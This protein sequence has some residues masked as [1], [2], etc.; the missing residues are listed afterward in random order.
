M[1]VTTDDVR[2]PPEPV[3]WRE[4]RTIHVMGIC[5]SAM[6]AFAQMLVKRGYDVQGSDRGAYPPMSTILGDLG[7]RVMEGYRADNLIPRPDVVVVGNVI[8][9]DYEEAVA[10]REAGIPHCS[11]PQA[12]RALFLADVQ[13]V[14]VAGT[15]GKTTTSSMAAWILDCAGLEPGFMIGGVT[16]NFGVS[17]RAGRGGNFVVEGD[18]YDTAY[19]DKGPKFLHY[20]PHVAVVNNIEYDHA[21]IYPSVEAI[22]QAFTRFAAI[23]DPA[24]RI[25]VADNDVRALRATEAAS[26]PRWT[27]GLGESADVGATQI[28]ETPDGLAFRLRFPDGTTVSTSLPMWGAHNVRNAVAAAAAAHA[29]GVEPSVIA[30]ALP[31]F[32]PPKKRQELRGTA[33]G[34]PVY[35]DFGH[36]PTAIQATLSAFRSRYYGRRVVAVVEIQS[37]TARRRVFQQGFAD[38]LAHA[39]VVH[40]GPPL[41]KASDALKEDE[42]L[43]LAA[44]VAALRSGGTPAFT[45]SSVTAMTDAVVDSSQ[46]DG[47]VV[48]VCSGRDFDGAHGKILAGLAARL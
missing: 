9:P 44:L 6:G 27:A 1:D 23:V 20:C 10:L 13:P 38:A 11:L 45:Y 18:E 30:A 25:I 15:H 4:V 35:D 40:F 31:T 34:I 2:R 14:V 3:D 41:E 21:D 12:L 39:D 47:D 36:H 17:A 48:V 22:E 43:D 46:P 8:R 5:G 24:G 33:L 26:A 16:G 42:R 28:V 19:F 32:Q 29:V 37:N 7:V